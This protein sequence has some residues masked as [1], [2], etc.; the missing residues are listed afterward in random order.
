[1]KNILIYLFKTKVNLTLISV[2]W[3]YYYN[4]VGLEKFSF[5]DDKNLKYI[6]ALDEKD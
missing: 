2:L 4:S 6:Y 1:M 5:S 3:D